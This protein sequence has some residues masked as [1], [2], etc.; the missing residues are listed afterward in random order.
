M[1]EKPFD[2]YREF[3]DQIMRAMV[4]NTDRMMFGQ[5]RLEIDGKPVRGVVSFEMTREVG[6]Y[7]GPTGTPIN[8]NELEVAMWA[9]VG[10]DISGKEEP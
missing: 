5:P 2:P 10:I 3:I 8:T 4:E 1:A 7:L 6:G 9:T